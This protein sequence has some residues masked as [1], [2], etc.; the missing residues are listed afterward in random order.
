MS[1]EHPVAQGT[2][3]AATPA[4]DEGTA[5]H[6]VE[7]EETAPASKWSPLAWLLVPAGIA[8]MALG[9]WRR[10]RSRKKSPRG[11]PAAFVEAPPP[12]S[13]NAPDGEQRT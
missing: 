3:E 5:S 12:P 4:A 7:A 13:A 10:A 1:G 9:L 6:T 11:E 2:Q 8:M